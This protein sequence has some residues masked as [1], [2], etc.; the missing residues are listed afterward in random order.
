MW[1]FLHFSLI[2]SYAIE[3]DYH[4]RTIKS[5]ICLG[6]LVRSIKTHKQCNKLH[7]GY[8]HVYKEPDLGRSRSSLVLGVGS[9]LRIVQENYKYVCKPLISC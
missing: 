2:L 3:T 5:K 9:D 4:Y 1:P 7:M 8:E 6:K